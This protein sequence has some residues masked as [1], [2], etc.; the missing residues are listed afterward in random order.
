LAEL[1][2][3]LLDATLA[4]EARSLLADETATPAAGLAMLSRV[5]WAV[6]AQEEGMHH[7]E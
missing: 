5:G 4:Q 7:A 6:E 2:P 3:G 1:L